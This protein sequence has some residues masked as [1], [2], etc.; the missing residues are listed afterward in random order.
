MGDLY[1]NAEVIGTDI[2]PMQPSWVPPNVSFQIDDANLEWTFSDNR[3]DFVHLRFLVGCITDWDAF[4]REAFRCTKPGGWIEHFEAYVHWYDDAEPIPEGST[5]DI[6]NKAFSEAGKKAGR[7]FDVLPDDIQKKGMEAAGFV[8]IQ[9]K[10]IKI[11][12][13]PWPEDAHEKELGL[14]AKAYTLADLEG[15][16][17]S[18]LLPPPTHRRVPPAVN[19]FIPVPSLRI[20]C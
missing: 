11:P 1:P 14:L 4:Y 7:T 13:G 17:H 15:M 2:T 3:F 8:D 19:F 20:V 6:Y 18:P 12:F 5:L 16:L 10:D 9:V